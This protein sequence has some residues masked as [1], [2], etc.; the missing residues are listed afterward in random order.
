MHAKCYSVGHSVKY[1][2]SC[3]ADNGGGGAKMSV[4]LPVFQEFTVVLRE[5]DM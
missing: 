4:C 2:C 5:T 1:C 3:C